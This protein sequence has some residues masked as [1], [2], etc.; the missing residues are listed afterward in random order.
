MTRYIQ[1]PII[2]RIVYSSIIQPYSNLFRAL[3]KTC[4]CKNLAYSESRNIRN[5]S[6]SASHAYSEPCHVYKN[7]QTLCNPGNSEPWHFDNCGLFR[8]LTY[9]KS[10]MY[11]ELSQRFKSECFAKKVKSY[12]DFSKVLILDL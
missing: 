8:T 7:T 9:L 11:S 6:I 12:N 5:S 10:D 2:V 3:C 1:T 4:I